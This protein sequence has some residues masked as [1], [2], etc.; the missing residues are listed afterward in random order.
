ML[1]QYDDA[2]ADE[3]RFFSPFTFPPL[4]SVVSELL[5]K[6]DHCLL[7]C[8]GVTL[9]ER[10]RFTGEAEKKLE[11][12]HWLSFKYRL[13]RYV[14]FMLA[15]LMKGPFIISYFFSFVIFPASQKATRYFHK[16]SLRRSKLIWKD[17]IRLLYS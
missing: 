14:W 6:N 17:L 3:V 8:Q 7:V 16:C 11:E 13:G 15:F 4:P 10:G 5:A 12:V 1:P 2:N 9:D